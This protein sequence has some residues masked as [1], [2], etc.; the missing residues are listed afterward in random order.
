MMFE[1]IWW[2]G[3]EPLYMKEVSLFGNL[4]EE[5]DFIPKG[6]IFLVDWRYVLTGD[7][8]GHVVV[9]NLGETD[10][11]EEDQGARGHPGDK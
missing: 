11:K 4:V 7:Y 6:M 2:T 5:Y 1:G 9:I 10:E 8:R 3:V